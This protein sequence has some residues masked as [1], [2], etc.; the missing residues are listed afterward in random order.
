MPSGPWASP[1]IRRCCSPQDSAFGSARS[2]IAEEAIR[3]LLLHP[4][5]EVRSFAAI[6][7]RVGGFDDDELRQL[8][9]RA[10]VLSFQGEAGK[11]LWD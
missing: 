10:G 4:D 3:S 11:E 5:W 7:R 2:T 1:R 8:L 6:K 9:V